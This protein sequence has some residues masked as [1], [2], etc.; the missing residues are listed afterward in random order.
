M[1]AARTFGP[2]GADARVTVP[3]TGPRAV[4]P[5]GGPVAPAPAGSVRLAEVLGALS[6]ALDLTEGQPKGHTLRCCR[7][8]ILVGRE[9]GLGD[10][11]LRVAYYGTLLKDLGCS[12]NAA[13]I[14]AL[15]LADDIAFKGD[16]KL[17]GTSL[18]AALRFVMTHTGLRSGL[19]ERFGAIA[20]ILRNGG[21]IA[22][23]LIETRCTRG[24]DIALRMRFGQPV[25]DAIAALDEHH[26]GR[27]KPTGTAGGEIPVAARLAL[28][29]QV[30]DVFHADGG[31]RAA[32]LEVSRRAGTWFDPEV[33]AAFDR[34]SAMDGFWEGQDDPGI[35]A[36]VVALEPLAS[37]LPL[38]EDALD[39]V[40]QG[41]AMVIDGKSPFTSNH[42]ERVAVYADMIAGEMGMPDAERRRLR[43]AGLLHDV[44]KLAVSNAVLDKPGRPD[45]AEWEM[46][47]SHPGHGEAILSRV[48]G[49]EDLA[50]IAGRHHE[51]LDGRG[52]PRG[53]VADAIPHEVRVMSV[54]D[55][56]DAL[57]ADRPYR[58]AM[59]LGEALAVMRRDSGTAFDPACL[60][61]LE[62]ALARTAW[63]REL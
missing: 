42:S 48:T 32:R 38:D 20:N 30:A 7:I 14:C 47:R 16:F 15:Y 2:V 25:A 31:P 55:V 40:A 62:R 21:T 8:A 4:G 43:R 44:G 45:D 46:I 5:V 12:S 49:F 34:V 13:R 50:G 22:R 37:S 41:F 24:A 6:H 19:A 58:A 17:M 3:S 10:E 1:D 27:G 60:M 57:T 52:Y 11:E 53:L 26:D 39:D 33:A 35:D 59:P 54:A 36:A 56:F 63:G 28:V 29:A 9:M 23:E 61:A 51:R 18:P